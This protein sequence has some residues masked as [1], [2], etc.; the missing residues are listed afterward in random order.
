MSLP[1]ESRNAPMWPYVTR[2]RPRMS[3]QI[4]VVVAAV[5]LMSRFR[6]RF[7]NASRRKNPRLLDLTRV[8]PLSHV[9]H[10]LALLQ[11][12]DPLAHH[13]HHLP[14]VGRHDHCGADAVDPVQELHYPDAGVRVEV[15]GWFVGDEDRRLGDEGAGDADPLLL[16]AGELIRVR[17]LLA[18]EADELQ[19]LGHPR[20]DGPPLLAG[21]FHRV[22]DVLGG[23]LVRQQLEVLEHAAYVPAVLGHVAARDGR[24]LR[25]VH[26]DLPGGRLLLLEDKTH[27]RGLAGTASPDEKDE[28]TGLHAEVHVFEGHDVPAVDLGY[29]FEVDHG[30]SASGEQKGLPAAITRD[31]R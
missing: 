13:V 23:G 21:Y 5:T 30:L 2:P 7:F 9:A 16:A 4:T 24:E 27:H 15:A 26:D 18:P 6:R 17:A 10:Y 28:L 22:G 12:H 25:A 29:V 8:T 20:A 11:R 19:D 1:M 14:V 3:T 31:H